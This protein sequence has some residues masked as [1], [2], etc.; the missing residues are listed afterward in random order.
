MLTNLGNAVDDCLGILLNALV[1]EERFRHMTAAIRMTA[2]V[3]WEIAKRAIIRSEAL[4]LKSNYAGGQAGSGGPDGEAC[5]ICGRIGHTAS[6]C[7]HRF[8]LLPPF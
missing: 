1:R 6:T 7:Y 3:T 8:N 5:Q 4:M 2:D